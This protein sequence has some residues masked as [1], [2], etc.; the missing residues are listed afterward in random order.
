MNIKGTPSKYHVPNL[1]RALEIIELLANNSQ[2]LNSSE[3]STQSNIPRNSIFRI[4]ATLFDRG[5][6]NRD[7]DTK[8][9]QLSQKL[10][11]LGYNALTEE[12]LVEK[13]LDH[14]RRLRDMFGETVPLGVLHGHEGM[15]IEEVP[16]IH[17]FRFVLE[18]G[19]K[20]QLHTAAP[21][22]AMIAFLPKEAQEKI[23]KKI[24]FKKYSSRTILSLEK[25]R[26]VL[27]K[28]R[29]DGYSIDHAEEIEGMHCIS[30]PVF[31]RHGKPIAAI[32]ITGPSIRIP[33]SEFEKI[34]KQVKKHADSISKSLGYGL[35]NSS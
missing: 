18:P 28:V 27:T 16:G 5:Y 29:K 14:M 15:V 21:G 3:I 6:L 12:S 26:R 33:E 24:V 2:G 30:A 34:G 9:F 22:K 20:F 11:V 31:N 19:R 4:T 17:S 23:F 8:A 25:Y 1:E 35:I 10:L 13:A 32:W 7:E